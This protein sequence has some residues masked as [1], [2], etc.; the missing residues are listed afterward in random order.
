MDTV[1]QHFI[2]IV[3]IEHVQIDYLQAIFLSHLL[4]DG[5]NLVGDDLVVDVPRRLEGRNGR[6]QINLRFRGSSNG[7]LLG[8]LG[9]LADGLSQIGA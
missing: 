2:T 1:V 4:L 7:I 9:F 5:D 3:G 6:T 8:L